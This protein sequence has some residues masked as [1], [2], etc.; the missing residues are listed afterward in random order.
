MNG[1]RQMKTPSKIL[2]TEGVTL[3]PQHF[4]QQDRYRVNEYEIACAVWTRARGMSQAA[5]RPG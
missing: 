2:W 1:S 3:R 4:Q 5:Q